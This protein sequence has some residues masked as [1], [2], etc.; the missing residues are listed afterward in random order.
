MVIGLIILAGCEKDPLATLTTTAVTEIT[1]VSAVSGGN[2]TVAEDATVT[3]RGVCWGTAPNPV[4]GINVTNEGAGDGIFTSTLTGLVSN[5]PYYVRAYA[6]AGGETYYGNEVTFTTAASTELIINGDFSTPTSGNGNLVN[7]TPWKTDEATDVDPADGVLDLVG[8]AFDNYKGQT[9]R[10][11]YHDWAESIYQVVGM[12]PS[13]QTKYEIS[14]KTTCTWNDWGDT[15]YQITGVIFSAYSGSDPTTRVPIDTVKFEEPGF[16]G[17]DLNVWNT[18]TGTYT[19]TTAKATANAGKH[20]VIEFDT[21][22][23]WDGEWASSAWYEMDDFS[24][25]MSSVK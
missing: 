19:L 7:A 15:F 9:G 8:Q 13:A 11:W 22:H 12:V 18:K 14:L 24:V 1:S 21:F 16:P 20:L 17:W 25:K 23:Y 10:L 6:T 3:A 2:V 5:T 4:V